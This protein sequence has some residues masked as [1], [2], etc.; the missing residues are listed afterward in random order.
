VKQLAIALVGLAFLAGCGSTKPSRP[1]ATTEPQ[2]HR[3]TT[4]FPDPKA[5][6][7]N[8]LGV[9]PVIMFHRVARHPLSEYDITPA[10]F[11][12]QLRR[13]YRLGYRPITASDLVTGNIDVAAGKSPVV[14]TFDD[15]SREQFRLL[16]NGEVDPRTAVGILLAF[17]RKH[18]GFEPRATFFVISGLFGEGPAG[19][20]LLA[21]LAQRGFDIGDHTYDHPNLGDLN[22]TGVQREIVLGD[23]MISDAVPEA[24][25]RTFALPYGIYP[26]R[27]GLAMRGRWDGRSYHFQGVFE[28][29]AG[30]TPSPYRIDFDPL[31]IPR[32]KVAPWRGK[33]D[34]GSG[35]WITYLEDHPDRRYVSDGNPERISFPAVLAGAVAPRFRSRANPY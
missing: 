20:K 19:A 17:A 22:A 12:R 3:R 15:S 4:H 7:A 9:I 26:K 21:D 8:E 1:A 2:H 10:E 29:G 14:L 6:G 16:P 28:V 34:L 23:Q 30:P 33:P 13:L 5:I 11:R 27:Q 31:A 18:P 35:Y 32:I 25:V 24:V